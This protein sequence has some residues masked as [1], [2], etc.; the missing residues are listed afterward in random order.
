MKL[1]GRVFGLIAI[2]AIFAGTAVAEEKKKPDATIE[3]T[4]GSVAAG[5]GFSWGSGVVTYKGK[6]H[7]V[8]VD[9]LSVGDVGAAKVSLKG[10]L[11]NLKKLEDIE[12]NYAAV[13]AGATLGGG[14][15]AVTMRNQNGVVMDAVSTT[16]GLKVAIATG[17]VNIKLED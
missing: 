8:K 13:G 4:G 10:H 1:F 6:T 17:G 12:G 9:G 5:I 14:G 11:Y 7:K 3:F 2:A 15:G 16:Q